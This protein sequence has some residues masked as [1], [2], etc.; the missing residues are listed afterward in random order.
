[1][2]G[3]MDN[4]TYKRGETCQEY[5]YYLYEGRPAEKNNLGE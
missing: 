3:A 5:P 1:M 2:R 4:S